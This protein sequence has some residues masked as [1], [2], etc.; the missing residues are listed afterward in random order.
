MLHWNSFSRS[1]I[2]PGG[3]AMGKIGGTLVKIDLNYRK[4][5]KIRISRS[6]WGGVKTYFTSPPPPH[7]FWISQEMDALRNESH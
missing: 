1:Y 2:T 4:S 7:E 3:E 6:K 5:V